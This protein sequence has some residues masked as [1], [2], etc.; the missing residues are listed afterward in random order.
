MTDTDDNAT[1]ANFFAW[2]REQRSGAL[3]DELGQELAALTAA[4]IEH[5]K[6]GTLTLKIGVSPT[7][8]GMTVF[9]TDD[10]IVSAPKADRGGSIMFPDAAGQLH[11]S[12]PNQLTIDRMHVVQTEDDDPVVVD[13]TTGEVREI[14]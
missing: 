4:V 5:G 6:K 13:T 2:L 3:H 8:D 9:V 7:K 11:R 12:N 1:S 14:R 10:V